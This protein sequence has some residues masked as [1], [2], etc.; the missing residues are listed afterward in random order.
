MFSRP[1]S[2]SFKPA[3]LGSLLLL[4]DPLPLPRLPLR[5]PLLPLPL[6]LALALASLPASSPS[7]S[8]FSAGRCHAPSSFTLPSA[9]FTPAPA[10]ARGTLAS[11]RLRVIRR[12][13]MLF[14]RGTGLELSTNDPLA[15]PNGL[16]STSGTSRRPSR[17][18]A[19]MGRG[20]CDVYALLSF[21]PANSGASA[22]SSSKMLTLSTLLGR[23]STVD[24]AAERARE[25]D[26]R[27]GAGAASMMP[28]AG[29][30]DAETV[31]LAA[32]V[33]RARGFALLFF[34]KSGYLEYNSIALCARWAFERPGRF[35]SEWEVEIFGSSS[36]ADGCCSAGLLGGLARRRASSAARSRRVASSRAWRALPVEKNV[37]NFLAATD[38]KPSCASF[39]S[40]SLLHSPTST[41]ELWLWLASEFEKLVPVALELSASDSSDMLSRSPGVRY[42]FGGTGG[43]TGEGGGGEARSGLSCEGCMPR[44]ARVVWMGCVVAAESESS[45]SW[46]MHSSEQYKGVCAWSM[47]V[48]WRGCAAARS[49]WACWAWRA[50]SSW[51]TCSCC[52]RAASFC[53]ERRLPAFVVGCWFCWSAGTLWPESRLR[54]PPGLTRPVPWRRPPPWTRALMVPCFPRVVCDCFTALLLVVVVGAVV[55][56]CVGKMGCGGMMGTEYRLGR[57]CLSQT[58]HQEVSRCSS[59]IDCVGKDD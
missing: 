5:T 28:E 2:C 18:F 54:P 48:R 57:I 40:F 44:R 55:V 41:G 10:L 27:M 20:D 8:A 16:R 25:C 50:A 7:F 49:T 39:S 11:L 26:V 24:D 6:A 13:V 34:V 14:T 3:R 47:T 9:L 51:R 46:R 29:W 23:P 19:R 43:R 53:G 35:E 36:A 1:R 15:L 17:P 58:G 30:Y 31:G 32:R 52:C 22:P 12:L 56:G 42:E 4:L 59:I 21:L 38:I 45:R 33:P 37:D